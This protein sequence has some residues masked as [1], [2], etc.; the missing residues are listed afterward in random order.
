M[1]GVCTPALAT[2][3]DPVEK[4]RERKNEREKEQKRERKQ[5]DNFSQV[6][7]KLVIH[8]SNFTLRYLLKR[9]KNIYLHQRRLCRCSEHLFI[10]PMIGDNPEIHLPV[11]E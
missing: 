11:N 6:K 5:S 4:E 9:N 10:L 2:E 3:R 7:D 1:T 8:S